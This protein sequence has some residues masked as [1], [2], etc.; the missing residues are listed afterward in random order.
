MDPVQA[1]GHASMDKHDLNHGVIRSNCI[2]WT[3]GDQRQYITA[4]NP[5][6]SL[7]ICYA[8]LTQC[9]LSL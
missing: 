4:A 5:D 9:C 2:Y 7:K 8:L 6:D 3:S 1:C